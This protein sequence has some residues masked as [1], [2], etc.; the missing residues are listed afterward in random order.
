MSVPG[1]LRGRLGN[2][3]DW[4]PLAFPPQNPRTLTEGVLH[5]TP[6]TTLYHPSKK[7]NPCALIPKGKSRHF[8]AADPQNSVRVPEISGKCE[9]R[10]PARSALQ[11]QPP[12]PRRFYGQCSTS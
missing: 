4:Y 8:H 10:H 11:N 3:R 9:G 12:T 6:S 1:A 5:C 7:L 2:Y